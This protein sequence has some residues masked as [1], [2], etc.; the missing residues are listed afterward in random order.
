MRFLP[1]GEYPEKMLNKISDVKDYFM[2]YFFLSQKNFKAIDQRKSTKLG[3]GKSLMNGSHSSIGG[4]KE[5]ILDGAIE[6]RLFP[7]EFEWTGPGEKVFITGSFYDWT[8]Q[9][10]LSKK[11]N[12]F[13]AKIDLPKGH[14]EFKFIINGIWKSSLR[15]PTVTNVYGDTNNCIDI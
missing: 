2:N 12:K 9:I 6:K 13:Y 14:H 1:G 3:H 7:V 11:S 8:V 4:K 10:P 15:Y 5:K